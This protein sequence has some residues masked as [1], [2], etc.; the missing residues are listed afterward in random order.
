MWVVIA[1]SSKKYCLLLECPYQIKNKQNS[2]VVNAP[3]AKF[4]SL[5][6]HCILHKARIASFEF[7][8]TKREF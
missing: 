7:H 5:G 3:V 8:I 1:S 2:F 6:I 4:L